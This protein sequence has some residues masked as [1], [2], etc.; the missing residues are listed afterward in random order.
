MQTVWITGN[1]LQEPVSVTS[2]AWTPSAAQTLQAWQKWA[3]GKGKFLLLWRIAQPQCLGEAGAEHAWGMT[4]HFF[5]NLVFYLL[6]RRCT[7]M[8]RWVV[9]IKNMLRYE[10]D[11]DILDFFNAYIIV[12][13]FHCRLIQKVMKYRG[14]NRHKDDLNAST[15]F[16]EPG[17]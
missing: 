16:L 13:I 10:V 11:V 3:R 12:C 9:I 1:F 14:L 6:C 17:G 4:G 7:K 8:Y 15:W 2:T 5:A